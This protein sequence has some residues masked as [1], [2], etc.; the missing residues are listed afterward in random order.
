M[1]EMK[2]V[3]A[4]TIR[5]FDVVAAYEEWD[6]SLG[7]E[8]PGDMLDGK[9]GMF[10][11]FHLQNCELRIRKLTRIGYRMYGVMKITSKPVDGMPTRVH[12]RNAS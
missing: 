8:K 7:R 3:L 9:R 1:L 6:R 4:L 11:E 5:D 12:R 10:G 2:I